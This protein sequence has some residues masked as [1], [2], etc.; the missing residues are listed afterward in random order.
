MYCG[1]RLPCKYDDYAFREI[2]GHYFQPAIWRKTCLM[3]ILEMNISMPENEGAANAVMKSTKC[4]AIEYTKTNNVSL[5]TMY[6]PHIHAIHNG[7][8]TFIK[9]PQLKALMESYGI[10]T[11][12]RGVSDNWITEFQ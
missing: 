12:T 5:P 6:Y 7:K 8:W 1:P 2:D 10:D 9:Y 11:S 3:K 4:Y